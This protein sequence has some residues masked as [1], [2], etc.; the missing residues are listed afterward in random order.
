MIGFA[1]REKD[2]EVFCSY[3]ESLYRRMNVAIIN[4]EANNG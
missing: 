3:V 4:I 2:E 1:G